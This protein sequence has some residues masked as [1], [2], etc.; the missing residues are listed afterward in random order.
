[1]SKPSPFMMI[2]GAL[3]GLLLVAMIT[4]LILVGTRTSSLV[5]QV[6]WSTVQQQIHHKYPHVEQI[7]VESLSSWLN[8][9]EMPP[10]LLLDVREEPE[11]QVSHLQGA[12]RIEP[13]ELDPALPAGVGKDTPI[14]AYC[15]V[16]ERSSALIAR[17]EE[18]GYTQVANLRGSIFEWAN[19]GHPVVRGSEEVRQVHPYDERWGLL[20]DEEL[21]TYPEG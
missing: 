18:L 1:M 19:K 11:Y 2:F 5:G 8:S 10:P 21:H 7:T 6:S 16:G 4:G 20:L 14:V 9:M 17:L 3:F 13:G 12:V 15:S